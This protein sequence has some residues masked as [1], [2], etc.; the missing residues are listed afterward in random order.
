VNPGP[1]LNRSGLAHLAVVYVVWG[2]TYLAIRVAVREGAGFPPFSMAALRVLVAA[3]LLLG[4]GALARHRLR[5]TRAELAVLAATGVML[6]TTANGLVTWAEQR[7]DSG[8]AALLVATMP[9]WAAACEYHLERRPPT[10]RLVAS[11]LTGFAGVGLL[12]APILRAGVHADVQAVLALLAAPASWAIGSVWIQ[13]RRPDLSPQVASGYQQLCGGV[14]FVL[15]A[16][17]TGEPRPQ[18]TGEAWLAW[19]YLVV[20]GSVVAFTSF[21]NVLRLLPVDVG[22]TYAYANPVVAVFLG[23]L[24]LREPITWWTLAGTVLVV[25][26]VV[27]V[28]RDRRTSR[29][30]P[31]TAAVA[32]D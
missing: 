6:W 15:L 10:W 7:A 1:S 27:G 19:G 28:F 22:M 32:A 31:A 18:P 23:W 11:L 17:L 14:G 16:L 2:S 13:R 12:T 5:P 20:F 24:I 9:L 4:W 25:A 21:V 8:L 30:A 3:A 26:G 29:R